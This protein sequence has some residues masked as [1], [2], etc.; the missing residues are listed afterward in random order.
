[1]VDVVSKA[2][3]S[4][5]MAEVRSRN[6]KPERLIRGLLHKMGYRFSLHSSVVPGHPDIALTK[7]RA[8]I[9]IHGCFWHGH[10]CGL[11]RLPNTRPA[12]W[13]NKALVN[14]R[15]DKAVLKET[16]ECEWR[17]LTV[18]ECSF[19]GPNQIGIDKVIE[20]ID[21]WLRSKRQTGII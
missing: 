20:K 17:H 21:R 4:R 13:R 3:R 10:D 16:L 6:T 14:R 15:R 9:H 11:Y 12:F 1:M 7:Y 19:R 2:T 18:W 8:A 5:M